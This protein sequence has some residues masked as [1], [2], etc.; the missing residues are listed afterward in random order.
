MH[1]SPPSPSG[2]HE[3]H[4]A[5]SAAV[6]Q[7][8]QAVAVLSMLAAITVLARR[9]P[10]PEFGTYGLLVSLTTYLVFVQ[11]SVETAAVKA[12]AEA[13]DQQARDRAFSTAASLYA[14]AGLV[15]G[16]VIALAGSALLTLFDIPVG[17]RHEAQTSV[18]VLAA[19]TA[20]GWPLKVFQDV[21]RGSQRF[22]LAALADVVAYLGI[23]SLLVVLAFEAAPLWVLVGVGASIPV[24]TGAVSVILV[25]HARL[26]CTFRRQAVSLASVRGFLG[27]SG[28]LF[29]I[30]I[31]DLVIYSLDRAIL[32]TFR[33]AAT[34]GLYEGPIRAHNL[35][36]QVN[37]TLSIPVVP[38]AARYLATGDTMRTRE[39]FLRGTRYTVAAVV[40]LTIVLMVLAKPILHVWLGARFETAAT[41]MTVLLAY[42]LV[43]ANTGVA[44]GMLVA[45]GR[46][47]Q[48]TLYAAVVAGL[49]LVLSLALTPSFGLVGVVLGTTVSYVVLFPFFLAIALPTFSVS[50]ADLAREAWLP[51]YAT[52]LVVGVGLILVRLSAHLDNLPKVVVAAALGLLAYWIIYYTVWLRPSERALVRNVALALVRR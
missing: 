42:W 50:L 48:L 40:P 13:G 51:G 46:A 22:A 20:A 49:N 28:Y 17:L 1:R 19:I 44:A 16:A 47:R 43:N 6:Q 5:V 29:F 14:G 8:S 9:L 25:R 21:L 15:A 30:G 35:V 45:A 7:I 26:S 24:A 36:R 39:L 38:A 23:G 33:S 32:A 10:L 2:V 27:L 18:L 3:R 4:L 34:V 12:I 11:G 37:G 52:G 31:A 41:G